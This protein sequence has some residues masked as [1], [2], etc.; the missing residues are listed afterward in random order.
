V[1]TTAFT[2]SNDFVL[3]AKAPPHAVGTVH[4]VVWAGSTPSLSTAAD[5]FTYT[6]GAVVLDIS[7]E[8]GPTGGGTVV[9]IFGA[10]FN[11]ATAVT[12]G[13]VLSTSVSLVSDTLLLAKSPPHSAGPV[14]VVVWV[15]STPSPI[16]LNDVFTYT[17]GPV[18][19]GVSP[20]G[21]PVSGG[22]AVTVTGA[23]FTGATAVTFG[24]VAGSSLAV[25][26]DN[27][28]VVT[29]PPHAAGTI[30]LVVWVGAVPSPLTV[31]DR[32]TYAGGPV[33]TSISPASGSTAGG[34]VVTVIGSGFTGTSA[35]TFGG[36]AGAN[37]TLL[38]DTRLL[39]TSPAHAAGGVHVQ[40]WVGS[41]GSATS[42]A[43]LF[44]YT[45]GPAVAGVNP[46]SGSTAGGTVVTVSGSGFTGAT[47]V[48]FGGTAGSALSV[49]SDTRL[50]VTTP[51]HAA[52]T[53]DVVVWVGSV[54]SAVSSADLFTFTSAAPSNPPARFAGSVVVA[55]VGAASGTTVEARVGSAVCGSTAV[56]L[57]GGVSRYVVD[58]AA[59]DSS[60]PGCGSEGATVTFSIGGAQANQ[61]GVWH[62]YQLNVLDLTVGAVPITPTPP[63]PTPVAPGPPDTGGGLTS[64]SAIPGLTIVGL[65]LMAIA[66]GGGLA[67]LKRQ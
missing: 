57:E 9:S 25:L 7:P 52:G 50:V 15:D 5:L 45:G 32:F 38:S 13:G 2:V 64:G 29:S 40:V 24:G 30:D 23:G 51:A 48:T 47:A 31:A 16:T 54:G 66:V 56:F 36:S 10:G 22:T 43:D 39:V 8:F 62:S 1:P 21:G 65:G 49:T 59:T 63:T 3:T 20:A 6:A 11:D 28:L 33:V 46:S 67:R 42:S 60:H 14:D 4:V 18:V 55:G 19:M 53:V 37:V 26:S 61:A 41:V 35:V 34:T 44:T 12:F 58:V 27:L 17:A